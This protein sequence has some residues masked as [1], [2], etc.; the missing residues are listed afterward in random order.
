[1]RFYEFILADV[2]VALRIATTQPCCENFVIVLR[3]LRLLE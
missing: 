1:M 2:V 3:L